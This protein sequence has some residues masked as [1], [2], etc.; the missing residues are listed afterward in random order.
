MMN[1]DQEL[2]YEDLQL[3]EERSHLKKYFTV[4]FI[5]YWKN[6]GLYGRLIL[7][8]LRAW[9]F[10]DIDQTKSTYKYGKTLK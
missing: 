6:S 2:V 7:L 1:Y 3:V 10:Y 4:V 8:P 5:P 9:A